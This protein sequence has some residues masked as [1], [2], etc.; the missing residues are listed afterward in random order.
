MIGFR[1]IKTAIAIGISIWIARLLHLDPAHFAGVISMLAVQPSVYRSLRHTLSH[2]ASALFAAI[3]GISV[4]LLLGSYSILIALVCLVVMAIHVRLRNTA[5]LTLAVIIAINTMG[6]ADI[7][8]GSAAY[9]Q[10]LLVLVGMT[11]GTMVNMLRKPVHREREEVLLAKSENM[12]RTLLY[13]IQL[14]LQAK[15]MTP[16]KPQMRQQIDEVRTYIEKGKE[17]AQLVNEDKWLGKQAGNDPGFMFTTYE[18]MVERVRDLIKALQKADL[19]HN[20]AK[21]LIRAVGLVIKVQERSVQGQKTHLSW[22]METLK[23]DVEACGTDTTA[24]HKL[25][26]Y[27]QA[28]EALSDYLKEFIETPKAVFTCKTDDFVEMPAVRPV[29]AVR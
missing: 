20:E 5:S 29:R 14:D 13:Y 9:H 17:I 2:I 18:T 12:L 22:V 1:V 11:V 26:P 15:R 3:L 16:Y 21:R 7:L 28:Y 10:F 6:T 23:P 19:E 24:L 27:Y 25:F 8:S 4:A